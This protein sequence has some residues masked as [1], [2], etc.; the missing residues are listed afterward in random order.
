MQ[1]QT[2]EP[3]PKARPKS[4]TRPDS[5]SNA[6]TRSGETHYAFYGSRTSIWQQHYRW[7]LMLKLNSIRE[8]L[9]IMKAS[10][11]NNNVWGATYNT[12]NNVTTDAGA[13]FEQT[14]TGMT[15][16]DRQP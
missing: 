1:S 13:G 15:V 8:R 11:H 2:Q 5:R 14:L 7:Y 3:D 4:K 16:G 10:P 6:D 12:R 9:N